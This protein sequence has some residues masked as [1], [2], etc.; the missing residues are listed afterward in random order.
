MNKDGNIYMLNSE[1]LIAHHSE[2]EIFV[3]HCQPMV[4]CL[5]ETCLTDSINDFEIHI[6]NYNIIRVD[7]DSRHTG[8][9]MCY[10]SNKVK[11]ELVEKVTFEKNY[12][13]L[14]L[15]IKDININLACVYHS[16]SAS[17]ADFIS[18]FEEWCNEAI[19]KLNGNLCVVGDFNLNW[20]DNTRYYPTKFR[21]TVN[22]L[23][24]R[25]IVPEVTRVTN[26]SKTMIDLVL[27]NDTSLSAM[28]LNSPKITDH[29]IVQINITLTKA[30]GVSCYRTK[31]KDVNEC[32]NLLRNLNLNYKENNIDT[33][34]NTIFEK[35]FNVYNIVRPKRQFDEKLCNNYW[36]NKDVLNAIQE[37]DGKYKRFKLNGAIEDWNCYKKCRNNVVTAIR[38]AK[39]EYYE[40]KIDNCKNDSKEMWKTL[41]TFISNSNQ[42]N[43]DKIIFN[44]N[45]IISDKTEIVQ[46]FNK[47][48]INSI[49][50]VI[51][52][53]PQS[54]KEFQIEQRMEYLDNFLLLNR[55]N[56]DRIVCSLAVKS[57]PDEIGISF[58][59]Q[60]IDELTDPI[61]HIVNYSLE[62]GVIPKALKVATI[63]PI[64][65][66]KGTIKASE[67]RPINML[68]AIEKILERTVY[69]QLRDFVEA[70]KMI[71]SFQSG[72]REGISCEA[73]VQYVVNEW[74]ESVDKGWKVAVI[75]L[76]LQRAFETVSRTKLIE[77]L[78]K[79]GIKD[80]VIKWIEDYLR[81]RKQRVKCGEVI[82]R[83]RDIE[84]GVPQGSI[85]G[86]LLF[87]L[88]IN[89]LGRWLKESKYHMFADDTII[90]LSMKNEKE[91]AN[92]LNEEMVRVNEWFC[93]NEL[94]INLGKTKIMWI[95]NTQG[96][97]LEIR[98]G[99]EIIEEAE[100]VKYLGIIIDNKLKF[101]YHIDFICGKIAKKLGV[102]ARTG[103]FLSIWSKK[104]IYNT[105]ILPHFMYGGTILHLANQTEL[106][107]LQKLQNRGMRI[108]LNRNRYTRITEMLEQ[109]QWFNVRQLLEYQVLIFI[110]KIE[111]NLVPDYFKN[112]LV[113]N[114][115]IH[116]HGTRNEENY[117]L[118]RKNKSIAQKGIL[119]SGVKSYNSLNKDIKDCNTIRTYKVKLR[120]YL[121][122]AELS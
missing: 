34:Y 47:F 7:S 19:L 38:R 31:I 109:L 99:N 112:I 42:E 14:V 119:F 23:G 1:S 120:S 45:K 118:N 121:R 103:K 106:N 71:D 12:W 74:K 110:K 105:I 117:Y 68:P 28:V 92:K 22:D 91:L 67:F 27:T 25:Q 98:I 113:K 43:Y 72:F 89:D 59:K 26:E 122:V 39:H 49:K 35:I 61:M 13:L 96:L 63:V 86:P 81:D 50:D 102:L 29:S 37:R 116:R 4:L 80:T 77:K 55:Q 3:R 114:K 9:V 65:K 40:T 78:R 82:S 62:T 115:D 5:T 76:D 57:S 8:G 6:E 15:Y 41:K 75:F 70:N 53:I 84:V 104:V 97:K 56:L 33:K 79:Y 54:K 32:R 108:I 101:N 93:A 95:G 46:E 18:S 44:E 17:D 60:F 90:Y 111:L 52:A 36:F 30:K 94:K 88:Y 10:I 69:E 48:Y 11:Y 107:R 100:K 24:L 85:L 20:L 21:N 66:I 2:I 16:P 87:I 58:I 51:K 73:A 64:R 83:E